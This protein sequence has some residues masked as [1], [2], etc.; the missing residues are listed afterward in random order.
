M[1]VVTM[2][3]KKTHSPKPSEAEHDQAQVTGTLEQ[4][5]ERAQGVASTKC[6]DKPKS[7]SKFEVGT[8]ILSAFALL[9]ASASAYFVYG[10]LEEMR[11]GM[12]V[13]QRAWVGVSEESNIPATDEKGTFSKLGLTIKNTGKTPALNVSFEAITARAIRAFC[14]WA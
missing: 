9:A 13:D 3:H 12:Q 6:P 7:I 2:A 4:R 1:N 5:L 8:L 11:T 14:S 10:Q